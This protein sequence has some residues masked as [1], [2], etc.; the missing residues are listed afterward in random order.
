MPKIKLS[1]FLATTFKAIGI[2]QKDSDMILAAS[3]LKEIELPEDFQS[4]FDDSFYTPDRAK[5]AL[6]SE[7]KPLHFG[8]FATDLEKKSLKPIIDS[9]PDEYKERINGLE[10]T[11]RLYN[12]IKVVEEA[13]SHVKNNGST[14]DI[15]KV[16]EVN[17]VKVE[18]LNKKILELDG[19]LKA[20]ESEFEQRASQIKTDYALRTKIFS[21]K[22]A[23]EFEK[24]KE[25]IAESTLASL[26][27]KN[28]LVE[29]DK[30]NSQVMH[31]RQKKDN[32]ITDVYEG[33]T[34]VSLDNFLE[35]ELSDF[36]L[37]SNGS[38]TGE[39][40]NPSNTTKPV[41]VIPSD[42]PQT[43]QEMIRSGAEV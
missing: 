11:N 3:A 41:H 32:A 25:F 6:E 39:T 20:K 4:K 8:H 19:T 29:F 27:S 33:N 40:T 10:K 7:L 38:G 1:D 18:D 37:K 30:E 16:N 9:L 17:R 43:L 35:K 13:Y 2:E 12:I 31:L 22:L 28:L 36:T 23:P 21:F 5:A 14:E 42:R 15:K 24:R 34:K 26:K